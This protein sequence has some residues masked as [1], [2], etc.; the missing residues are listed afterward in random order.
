MEIQH[1]PWNK[2]AD[3]QTK[4]KR[5]LVPKKIITGVEMRGFSIPHFDETIRGF[6]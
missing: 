5:R 2:Q 6:W 4:Q 1:F 3:G